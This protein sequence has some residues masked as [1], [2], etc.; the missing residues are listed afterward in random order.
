[1]AEAPDPRGQHFV[2]CQRCEDNVQFY[3]GPCKIRLCVK[4]VSPHLETN[5]PD[6]NI[7]YY[8]K[9]FGMTT[10]SLHDPQ[11]TGTIPCGY[12]AMLCTR[13]AGDGQICV[14]SH[15]SFDIKRF[16]TNGTLVNTLTPSSLAMYLT[17][18]EDGVLYTGTG[19]I[20]KVN[21]QGD[22]LFLPIEGNL[23]GIKF[24]QPDTIFVCNFSK[25]EKYSTGGKR[26]L[27]IEYNDQG[28]Q[29]YGRLEN[30]SI[31]GNEDICVSGYANNHESYHVVTVVDK[32]GKYRFTYTPT[33]KAYNHPVDLCC[34]SYLHIIIVSNTIHVIDKDGNFLRYLLYDGIKNPWSVTIDREDNL[35]VSEMHDDYLRM[36][37]Y[38]Y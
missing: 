10:K 29:I 2:T 9:R 4:C 28:E 20:R 14:S 16:Y 30:I 12:H 25:V 13:Y 34:D 37:K 36:M 5:A 27:E 11:I 17:P 6:H 8:H 24:V 7:V 31:N 32:Y 33:P 3:C 23:K 19:G 21:S 1:M 35:Y 38:M 26:L 18:N 15:V 22:K